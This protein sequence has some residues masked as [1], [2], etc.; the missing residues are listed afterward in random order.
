[1]SSNSAPENDLAH[2]LAAEVSEH[3]QQRSGENPF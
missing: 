1:M 2:E 3:E